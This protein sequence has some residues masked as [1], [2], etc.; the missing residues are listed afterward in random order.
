MNN[1]RTFSTVMQGVFSTKIV[2]V[3]GLLAFVG[4]SRTGVQAASA[5]SPAACTWVGLA[6]LG[7]GAAYCDVSDD[8]VKEPL[9][10]GA[11]DTDR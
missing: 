9:P 4:A 10:Q 5:S 7:P 1:V 2:L 3:V 8:I 6:V 11:T